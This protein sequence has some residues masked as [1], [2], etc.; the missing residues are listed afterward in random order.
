MISYCD[1]GNSGATTNESKVWR[2]FKTDLISG[3]FAGLVVC[4]TGHPFDSMKVRMQSMAGKTSF[5]GMLMNTLRREGIRGFYKGMGPPLMTVPFIN[6]IIFASYEFCKRGLGVE[7]DNDFTLAQ[8]IYCGMFSGLV[9]S[10]FLSP[11]EL[12]KCRLQIQK[13]SK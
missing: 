4:L 13:E 3:S 11:I 6:S 9:N 5:N 2:E 12:V 1:L 10:V 7:N 8:S